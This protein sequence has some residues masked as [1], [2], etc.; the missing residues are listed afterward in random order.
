MDEYVWVFVEPGNPYS[1]AMVP[2]TPPK[3]YLK[4]NYVKI[5][6]WILLALLNV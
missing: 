1:F 5:V 6:R 2:P 4:Y 3:K